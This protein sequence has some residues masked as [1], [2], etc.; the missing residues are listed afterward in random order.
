MRCFSHS[1]TLFAC[2]ALAWLAPGQLDAMR[3]T[4][5]SP[6]I[7]LDP[8]HGGKHLGARSERHSFEEKQFTLP[9]AFK[10]KRRLEALGYRVMMTRTRDVF[11]SLEDRA[12][13]ANKA[14]AD[15]F[16]SIHYNSAPGKPE[17]HGIE[18]YYFGFKDNRYQ[19]GRALAKQALDHLLKSTKAHSRGTKPCQFMVLKRTAMPAILVEG[20]FLTNPEERRLIKRD[21]YLDKIAAGIANGVHAYMRSR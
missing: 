10:V 15:L 4:G 17:I 2:A 9:T 21:C 12:Q 18:V 3:P 13:R 8:G 20:G 7:A 19:S 6:L 1:L 5:H 14:K 11:V 16:V